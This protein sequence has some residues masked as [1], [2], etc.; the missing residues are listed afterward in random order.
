MIR[1]GH[2]IREV[3]A[4]LNSAVS[5]RVYSLLRGV[6]VAPDFMITG[7]IGKNS[8]IVQKIEERVGLKAIVPE[9]PQIVGALGAALF[10]YERFIAG[11]RIK[12]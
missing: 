2:E 6:G 11:K 3:I 9:E 4:G 5:A 7:G 12:H 1:E 10:A 8:G